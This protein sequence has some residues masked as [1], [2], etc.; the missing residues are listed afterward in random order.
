MLDGGQN[1][2][3]AVIMGVV[4]GCI[5]KVKPK[6]L[7]IVQGPGIRHGPGA[8]GKGGR[9]P[10]MVMEG[11]LQIGK[12]HIVLHDAVPDG[13]E[14]LISAL[15]EP[16]RDKC[17]SSGN[18]ACLFHKIHVLFSDY[19]SAPMPVMESNSPSM[20]AA[21]ISTMNACWIAL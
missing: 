4:V 18:K 5:V 13:L 6:G 9:I 1:A 19:F 2:A 14:P 10:L 15:R 8:A 7:H 20:P 21:I 12:F 17:V 3:M 11:H 16:A